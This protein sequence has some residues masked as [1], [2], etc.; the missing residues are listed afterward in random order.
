MSGAEQLR[1]VDDVLERVA[2]ELEVGIVHAARV[3][4]GD[5]AISFRLDLDDGNL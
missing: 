4:G 3:H 1:F 2:S 5:V